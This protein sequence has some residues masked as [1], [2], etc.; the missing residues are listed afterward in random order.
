[1]THLGDLPK[2]LDDAGVAIDHLLLHIQAQ[3][4]PSVGSVV[5]TTSIES[6]QSV[7]D[8]EVGVGSRKDAGEF[9]G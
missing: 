8:V 4:A 7:P 9:T 3:V 5:H 1:V 6:F 2:V